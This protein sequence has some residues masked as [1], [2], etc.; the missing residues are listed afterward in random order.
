MVGWLHAGHCV[1]KVPKAM[2]SLHRVAPCT[3]N[4]GASEKYAAKSSLVQ[5]TVEVMSRWTD[6]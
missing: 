2:F 6:S 3:G 1:H 5:T 4:W